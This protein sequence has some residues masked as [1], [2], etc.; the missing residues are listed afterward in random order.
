MIHPLVL[1]CHGQPGSYDVVHHPVEQRRGY[2][3]A[4]RCTPCGGEGR[5]M[6]AVM[7]RHHLMEFLESLQEPTHPRPR[8]IPLQ[9]D[10][11]VVPVHG[12]VGLPKVQ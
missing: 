12:V 3:S 5:P 7:P 4:L 11:K 2:K 9:C 6:E 8:S 10:E 1:Y